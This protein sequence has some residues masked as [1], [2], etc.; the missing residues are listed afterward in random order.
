MH[1][2][3]ALLRGQSER[4]GFFGNQSNEKKY[5]GISKCIFTQ[6]QLLQTIWV[7]KLCSG[8]IFVIN[9]RMTSAKMWKVFQSSM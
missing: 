1:V 4:G 5:L 7:V 8:D 2:P 3:R 9:V 6:V